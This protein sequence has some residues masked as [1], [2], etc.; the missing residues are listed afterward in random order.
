MNKPNL[1]QAALSALRSYQYGNDSIDLAKDLADK[2]EAELSESKEVTPLPDAAI[3]ASLEDMVKMQEDGDEAGKGSRWHVAAKSALEGVSP[4]WRCFHCSETFTDEAAAAEHFG[5]SEYQQPACQID[6]K[7]YREM[8]E[9]VSRANQ[10]DSDTDRR[11]YAMQGEHQMALKREEEKGY[12]RGLKDANYLGQDTDRLDWLNKNHDRVGH[13]TGYRGA[14]SSWSWRNKAG[15]HNDA[16]SLR[17]AIDQAKSE[18]EPDA[19]A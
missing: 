2:I 8:E 11:M 6:A 9:R 4:C 14:P 18:G 17:D 19:R 7:Q 12:A 1:M 3:R 15:W 5:W 16:K 10:D 13:A